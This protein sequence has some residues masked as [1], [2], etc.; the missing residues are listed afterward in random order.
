[1]PRGFRL[2]GEA[3]VERQTKG[4]KNEDFF[5]RSWKASTV[6][7]VP[8]AERRPLTSAQ[9]ALLDQIGRLFLIKEGSK[10]PCATDALMEKL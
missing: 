6:T 1:M 2:G 3:N 5:I 8:P 10:E 4:R 7:T 9:E